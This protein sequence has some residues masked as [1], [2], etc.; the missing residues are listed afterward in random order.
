LST[1]HNE[2]AISDEEQRRR[3][4]IFTPTFERLVSLIRGRVR[5][6]AG[7]ED[8]HRD[9]RLD[10]KRGRV[11]IGDTLVDA[12]GVLGGAR[13]VQLLAEP[14]LELS[15]QVVSGKPFDWQTAEAA[16][17]CIR[18]IHRTAPPAGDPLLLSLFSSLPALPQPPQLAYTVAL[19]V[20]AY[21]DWLGDTAKGMGGEGQKLLGSLLD[22]LT[23][24]TSRGVF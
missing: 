19:T 4:A 5:F 18:C 8:W 17:Y 20:G 21:A 6:P 3:V 13:T 15:A 22:M 7:F 9:E 16:L 23:K 12:A 24:G 10:F 11:A 2:P 14:L 1:E